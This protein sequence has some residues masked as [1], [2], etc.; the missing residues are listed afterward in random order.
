MCLDLFSV[1][2]LDSTQEIERLISQRPM[3]SHEVN[4]Q[5]LVMDTTMV[6]LDRQGQAIQILPMRR[7]AE[8][9]T[10]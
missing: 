7:Y 3:K 5:F 4:S 1:A 6:Q 8:V 9:P 2:G 10:D